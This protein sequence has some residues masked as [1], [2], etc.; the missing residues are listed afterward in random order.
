[1]IENNTFKKEKENPISLL[2]EISMYMSNF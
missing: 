1:M 2:V